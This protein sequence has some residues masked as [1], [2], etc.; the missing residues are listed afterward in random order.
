[1]SNHNVSWKTTKI[2]AMG[3]SPSQKWLGFTWGSPNPWGYKGVGA[4]NTPALIIVH[5]IIGKSVT[6][7]GSNKITCKFANSGK[8]KLSGN[9]YAY[10]FIDNTTNIEKSPITTFT[11]LSTGGATYTTLSVGTDVWTKL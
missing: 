9:G 11:P 2:I 1:M 3:P 8:S 4:G 7:T 5:T 6:W 10:L